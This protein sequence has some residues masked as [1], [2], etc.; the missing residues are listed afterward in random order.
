MAIKELVYLGTP[1]SGTKEEMNFRAEVV[2]VIS[3]DLSNKGIMLYSPISSWHSIACK[4]NMPRNYAFWQDMC[5]TFVSKCDKV[6]V[7][8]LPGWQVSVG[9][10]GEIK[11]ALDNGI[12]VEY[13][14]PTPYLE[15]LGI[16]M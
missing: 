10:M 7:V 14:D 16:I 3:E 15:K 4:Y 1:Y 11:F 8:M 2:D 5:E 13:L 9:L 6:I 12:K